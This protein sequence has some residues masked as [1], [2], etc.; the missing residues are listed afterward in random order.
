MET[1]GFT[2]DFC[3]D[4]SLSRIYMGF[5]RAVKGDQVQLMRVDANLSMRT[6]LRYS[7]AWTAAWASIA[8]TGSP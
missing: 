4:A 2:A 6:I 1:L 5:L 8:D 7:I 3:D